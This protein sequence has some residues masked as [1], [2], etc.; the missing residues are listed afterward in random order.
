MQIDQKKFFSLSFSLQKL[1]FELFIPHPENADFTCHKV[2]G[3]YSLK[4]N[5]N[6]TYRLLIDSEDRNF[7]FG[8]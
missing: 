4:R 8:V 5:Q 7:F 6:T 2:L 3:A 1:F